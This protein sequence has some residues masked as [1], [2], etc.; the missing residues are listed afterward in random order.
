MRRMANKESGLKLFRT[1]RMRLA[2]HIDPITERRHCLTIDAPFLL[3]LIM[4]VFLVS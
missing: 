1:I 4:H 2:A 3:I